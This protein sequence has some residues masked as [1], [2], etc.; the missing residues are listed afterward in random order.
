MPKYTQGGN[1]WPDG[2]Y[3]FKVADASDDTSSTGNP[4]IVL[5]NEIIGQNGDQITVTDYLSFT[6]SSSGK[7]D[8]FILATGG[9]VVPGQEV[10]LDAADC[11]NKTGE[12]QL[13]HDEWGG[14]IKNKVHYYLKPDAAQPAQAPN[15]K[16]RTNRPF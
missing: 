3:R 16:P 5:Q 6:A 10:T 15:E 9:K 13:T 11:V 8:S 12:L 4:M 2:R 1:V 14:M 7:I